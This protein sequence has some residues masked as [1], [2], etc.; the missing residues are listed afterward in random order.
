[1]RTGAALLAED[2]SSFDDEDAGSLEHPPFVRPHHSHHHRAP[3]LPATTTTTTTTTESSRSVTVVSQQFAR[4]KSAYARRRAARQQQQQE[5]QTDTSADERGDPGGRQYVSAFQDQNIYDDRLFGAR[6]F[7][8]SVPL[9]V[10]FVVLSL[11]SGGVLPLV[12]YWVPAL[13]LRMTHVRCSLARAERLLV[14]HTKEQRIPDVVRVHLLAVADEGADMQAFAATSSPDPGATRMTELPH[15]ACDAYDGQAQQQQAAPQRLTMHV[16]E[17]KCFRYV[18]SKDYKAFV[19]IVFDTRLPF[20]AI[21]EY[22]NRGISD[23]ERHKRELLYGTNTTPIP[24]AFVPWLVLQELVS[25]F[26]VFQI[27]CFFLWVAEEYYTYAVFVVLMTIFLVSWNVIIEHR[28]LRS[29]A[30]MV[31]KTITVN[32]V[33]YNENRQTTEVE[34]ADSSTLIPGDVVALDGPVVLPCDMILVSGNVVVDESTLT[35]ESD[36]QLKYPLPRTGAEFTQSMHQRHMLFAGTQILCIKESAGQ[37]MGFVTQTSY[38]TA[39]GMLLRS[40]LHPP[41]SKISFM[42]D[43]WKVMVVLIVLSLGGMVFS[44][45]NSITHGEDTTDC[46]TYAFD[47]LASAVPP[48]LPTVLAASSLRAVDALRN[49]RIYCTSAK[50]VNEA[51]KIEVMAFD[52]TGTI[53]EPGLEVVGVALPVVTELSESESSDSDNPR[54]RP[55]TRPHARPAGLAA[56]AAPRVPGTARAPRR[57][58]RAWLTL[59]APQHSPGP[60]LPIL[61]CCHSL[62][63]FEGEIIGDPLEVK[64]FEFTGWRLEEWLQGGELFTVTRPHSLTGDSDDDDDVGNDRSSSDDYYDSDD[65]SSSTSSSTSSGDDSDD[66]DSD[67]DDSDD[68]GFVGSTAASRRRPHPHHVRWSNF[69]NPVRIRRGAD[70]QQQ[71]IVVIKRFDYTADLQRQVVVAKS[72]PTGDL[73]VMAKGS[74][75]VICAMCHPSTVPSNFREMLQEMDSQGMRV[76]GLAGKPLRSDQY[77][78]AI[79][80]EALERDLEFRGLLVLSNSV[81]PDSPAVISELNTAGIRTVMVTGDSLHTAASVAR[82]CGI[83]ASDTVVYF[84]E[85]RPSGDVEW[86]PSPP[87]RPP[88]NAYTLKPMHEPAPGARAARFDY[89]FAVHG[90]VFAAIA[91][92]GNVPAFRRLLKK[93]QVFARMKPDQKRALMEAYEEVLDVYAGMCGDG[94]NDCGALKAARIGLSLGR[95]EASIAAP[96]TSTV[97]SITV[98]PTLIKQGRCALSSSFALVKFM[99]LYSLINFAQLIVI[100]MCWTDLGD[101]EFFYLD[102]ILIIPMFFA[103]TQLRAPKTLTRRPPPDSI[104]S[105]PVVGSI[106][107]QVAIQVAFYLL[108]YLWA[109]SEPWF[110]YPHPGPEVIYNTHPTA[111]TFLYCNFQYLIVGIIFARARGQHSSVAKSFWVVLVAV[112]VLLSNI[113][114][115]F[116]N[117][118]AVSDFFDLPYGGGS[119]D[120]D[121]DDSGESTSSS[122][123]GSSSSSGDSE[124]DWENPA[125]IPY[126]FRF[127]ML[128][129][130]L[131]NFYVSFIAEEATNWFVPYVMDKYSAWRE[132]RAKSQYAHIVSAAQRDYAPST[133]SPPLSPSPGLAARRAPRPPRP[134]KKKGP[135]AKGKSRRVDTVESLLNTRRDQRIAEKGK[136]ARAQEPVVAVA[137]ERTSLL[138]TPHG[139]VRDMRI[140][141]N[142]D[143]SDSSS[144]ESER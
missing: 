23:G 103:L 53:T 28:D 88:L 115:L 51:G 7:R 59:T 6:G 17:Y 37:A 35:G 83:V 18:Y 60:A 85:L 55:H 36:P 75:E 30:G 120:D 54:S 127:I 49:K 109:K 105:L 63:V 43:A 140:C 39:K 79:S 77:F 2:D 73:A 113:F 9:L 142:E 86:T 130:V 48:E 84:G 1:M 69:V 74:P 21:H 80:R 62:T 71:G 129:V 41:P 81:K 33:K 98:V 27:G 107:V 13:G 122:A 15:S 135:V 24:S 93:T 12:C 58:T 44:A 45:W 56:A 108:V 119:G 100:Y 87:E 91:A 131:V 95:T 70:P 125:P 110:V 40:I 137:N 111:V 52:K 116:Q 133:H 22:A 143:T 42:A 4:G 124:I 57:R 106:V 89:V 132:A 38:D 82:Q 31:E 46:F 50:H 8:L 102:L 92:A 19:R 144:T 25:P 104:T 32:V 141:V 128:A 139:S 76:L 126:Y 114:L 20:S 14:T 136:F 94:A 117:I 96:F 26:W 34:T 112:G 67:S 97:Q 64:M 65:Y 68:E 121:G 123:A 101:W 3:P 66:S 118:P 134:P 29:L 10:L 61:A 47:I 99:V 72:L 90:R 5:R 11:A 16:A 78:P 138:W